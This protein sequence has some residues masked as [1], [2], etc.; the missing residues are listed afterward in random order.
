MK[1]CALTL[2]L[3]LPL[4]PP[5]AGN[6]VALAARRCS[7][8]CISM[9]AIPQRPWLALLQDLARLP[10]LLLKR[11][12]TAA[13]AAPGG[14]THAPIY[15][16]PAVQLHDQLAA[17]VVIHKLELAN[18]SYRRQNALVTVISAWMCI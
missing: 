17:A 13:Q 14:E 4:L 12:H 8:I 9:L 5:D 3:T 1:V 18:V 15:C 6:D 7:L 10:C 11:P 16:S 2:P